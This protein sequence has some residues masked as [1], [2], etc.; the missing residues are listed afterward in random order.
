MGHPF[1]PTPERGSVGRGGGGRRTLMIYKEGGLTNCAEGDPRKVP[2]IRSNQGPN[3]GQSAVID[4][5]MT[6]EGRRRYRTE[7]A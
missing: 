5:R 3:G 2:G 1:K 4:C 7:A 6:R